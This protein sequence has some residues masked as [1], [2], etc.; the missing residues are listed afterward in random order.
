ML[1]ILEKVVSHVRENGEG[2]RRFIANLDTVSTKETWCS[3]SYIC[4][5]TLEEGHYKLVLILVMD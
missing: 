3:E 2:L 5:D 1:T 4:H